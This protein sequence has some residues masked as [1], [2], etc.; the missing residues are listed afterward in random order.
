MK[1]S[2]YIGGSKI[3]SFRLPLSSLSSA[4]T[5]IKAVLYKYEELDRINSQNSVIPLCTSAK[6]TLGTKTVIKAKRE[7]ITYVCGCAVVDGLFRRQAGCSKAKM[8]H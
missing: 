1:T 7:P 2:K 4:I 3:V 8:Q 6:T 5:D